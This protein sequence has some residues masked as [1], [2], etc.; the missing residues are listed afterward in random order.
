MIRLDNRVIS[1][2]ADYAVYDVCWLT[3]VLSQVVYSSVGILF[4]NC[5]GQYVGLSHC[6]EQLLCIFD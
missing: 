3:A 2:A 4:L 6:A 1:L 5:V